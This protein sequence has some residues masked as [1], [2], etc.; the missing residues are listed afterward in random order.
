MKHAGWILALLVCAGV[1]AWADDPT[2]TVRRGDSLTTIARRHG[3]SRVEL[4]R[5]NNLKPDAMILI[6]QKLVI[7][8]RVAPAPPRPVLDAEVQRAI[9][10]VRLQPGRWK[11]IVIHHSGTDAGTLAGMD[12]F[13]REERRMENGLAYHFVIGNGK[14]M[15]DGRV[16]TSHRWTRQLD[17]G[18]LASAGQNKTSLGICLVGNFDQHPPTPK[19]LENLEA[20]VRALMKRCG[21]KAAAVKTH[22]QINVIHT[23]CPGEKFPTSTFFKS[24]G[25]GR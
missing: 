11:H 7:P 24:L 20:L 22:Q 6:G 13:H 17:G 5:R 1:S 4:A 15:P 3:V 16:E 2:Y 9:A 18:H 10:G 25:S 21:L 23:R 19:Q 14:G 12:R 8:G